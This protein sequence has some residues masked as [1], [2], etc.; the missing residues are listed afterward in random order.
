MTESRAEVGAAALSRRLLPAD[1]ALSNSWQ[2]WAGSTAGQLLQECPSDLAFLI[3][4]RYWNNGS[5]SG[6][7]LNMPRAWSPDSQLASFELPWLAV[8]AERVTRLGDHHVGGPKP[9]KD[10]LWFPLHPATAEAL[11]AGNHR[12]EIVY[13]GEVVPMA[14]GRTVA[15]IQG[16]VV[17]GQLKLH[18]PG[19]LGRFSRDLHLFKVIASLDRSRRMAMALRECHAPIALMAE[20]GGAVLE[21]QDGGRAIGYICRDQPSTAG[22]LIPLFSLWATAPIGNRTAL[23]E[24][25]TLLNRPKVEIVDSILTAIIDAYFYLALEHGLM[26]ELN[27]QN[28]VL[29]IVGDTIRLWIRDMQDVFVDCAQ[30][31]WQRDPVLSDYKLLTTEGADILQRRSFSY[32]FKLGS[33]IIAP[34]LSALEPRNASHMAMSI[35]QHVSRLLSNHPNYFPNQVWYR[36]RQSPV[37]GRSN[38]EEVAEMPRF[39]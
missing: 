35:R 22:P 27:A 15:M 18:Y 2:G 24:I 5:P 4:E 20:R 36:Y 37:V 32:D 9:G 33:Y 23:E 30:A 11:A 1:G 13:Q 12:A 28:L 39:R 16:T 10:E 34:L 25:A 26:P 6:F 17:T 8:A 29:E 19:V 7:G 31:P 14:S 21:W 38:Y 3:F